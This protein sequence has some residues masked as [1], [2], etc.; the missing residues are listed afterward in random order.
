MA[1]RPEAKNWCFTINNPTEEDKLEVLSLQD[2]VLY[3]VYG[4]EVGDN[5]TPHYQ[6][7]ACFKNK[8]RLT[9]VKKLLT[10]AHLE[11]ARGTPQ[12]ASDYCKKDGN[13]REFGELPATPAAAGGEALQ[14]KYAEAWAAAKEGRLEEV[15]PRLRVVH[16]HALRRIQQDYQKRPADLDGVCGVWY[17]GVPGS[18]KSYAARQLSDSYYD[19]PANKWF[20]GYQGE[21]T[22]IIDDLDLAHKVLGHQLKRWADRYAFP[23]EMKGTTIQIR[24]KRIVVTS[25]YSID[26]IFADDQV[27]CAALKRRFACTHFAQVYVPD[28]P[29]LRRQPAERQPS[30]VPSTA[31]LPVWEIPDDSE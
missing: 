26:E 16:Y 11:I 30:P 23:A 21:D 6:G 31:S 18:G 1:Q 19:K 7:Y 17:Y 24:P 27:L 4:E 8:Q 13:Y 20:D 5:G 10:R 29:Q 25:N 12:E 9:A 3:Y 2:K 28:R 14:A 22:V 15:D